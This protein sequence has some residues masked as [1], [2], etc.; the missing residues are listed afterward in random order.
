MKYQDLT[1]FDRDLIRSFA[2]NT[3]TTTPICSRFEAISASVLSC[4]YACGY[5]LVN[6]PKDLLSI[7]IKNITPGYRSAPAD[8]SSDDVMKL[9]FNQLEFLG[10][11]MMKSETRKPTWPSPKKS[12]YVEYKN[13]KKPWEIL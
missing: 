3:F 1:L 4:I 7:I 13:T 6:P 10:I 12:W 11:V 5:D 8:L 9:I 2:V